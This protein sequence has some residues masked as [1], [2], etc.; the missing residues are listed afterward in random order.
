[1]FWVTVA[2][3]VEPAEFEAMLDPDELS[4]MELFRH[5]LEIEQQEEKFDYHPQS[6]VQNPIH[7]IIHEHGNQNNLNSGNNQNNHNYNDNMGARNVQSPITITQIN[8]S[9]I[10]SILL[11][12]IEI[13][14]LSGIDESDSD[15]S[16]DSDNAPILESESLEKLQKLR[17]EGLLAEQPP[18]TTVTIN[19]DEK[20]DFYY[21]ENEDN[22]ENV[23][24]EMIFVSSKSHILLH[25]CSNECSSDNQTINWYLCSICSSSE[26]ENNEESWDGWWCEHHLILKYKRIFE[27]LGLEINGNLKSFLVENNSRMTDHGIPFICPECMDNIGEYNLSQFRD[28]FKSFL[29]IHYGNE[30]GRWKLKDIENDSD[31]KW[32]TI[33]VPALINFFK[34]IDYESEILQIYATKITFMNEGKEDFYDYIQSYRNRCNDKEQFKHYGDLING[35]TNIIWSQLIKLKKF[36]INFIC[37]HKQLLI[38]NKEK[39]KEKMWQETLKLVKT[40]LKQLEMFYCLELIKSRIEAIIE[41]MASIFKRFYN[42]CLLKS[43]LKKLMKANMYISKSFEQ[44]NVITEAVAYLYQIIFDYGCENRTSASKYKSRCKNGTTIDRLQ[45][46][47][48][49]SA[50]KL[51]CKQEYQKKITEWFKFANEISQ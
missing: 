39:F 33:C 6:Q 7:S 25:R 18:Y 15:D 32:R 35:D 43:N 5:R 2:D 17:R 16:D 8:D 24:N 20:K 30:S 21:D 45:S 42:P 41:V 1:M 27:L 44:R 37:K 28:M 12:I 9:Q 11:K 38:K 46:Q 51:N 48:S 14:G 29:N 4:I 13:A 40:E 36:Q 19:L 3:A 31:Y 50:L 34:K 23:E 26:S 47:H 49:T 10:D 22:N